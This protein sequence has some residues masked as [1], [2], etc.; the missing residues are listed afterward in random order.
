MSRFT[1]NALG[2]LVGVM[3]VVGVSC[4]A[5]GTNDK[6]SSNKINTLAMQA[7]TEVRTK[8]V[9]YAMQDDLIKDLQAFALEENRNISIPEAQLMIYTMC[10]LEYYNQAAT[11][12]YNNTEQ[13]DAL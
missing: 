9:P 1:R 7:N 10:V 5:V 4:V 12:I 8:C 3:L 11:I 6:L 2:F 13:L